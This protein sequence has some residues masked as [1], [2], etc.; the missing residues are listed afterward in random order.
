MVVASR[1]NAVLHQ[2]RPLMAQS[3]HTHS[4]KKIH[5]Y[6]SICCNHTLP[7]V[8]TYIQNDSSLSTST[9][10][11]LHSNNGNA[12]SGGVKDTQTQTPPGRNTLTIF[13]LM[14]GINQSKASEQAM[15]SMVPL[16][17]AAWKVAS[18]KER[19]QASMTSH[20]TPGWLLDSA[21]SSPCAMQV[22]EKST[23]VMLCHPW[24]YMLCRSAY[25]THMYVCVMRHENKENKTKQK[26]TYN[27]RVGILIAEEVGGECNACTRRGGGGG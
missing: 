22:S 24:S 10:H 26:V 23:L 16:S 15:A 18:S 6:I 7:L 8:P 14:R 27:I 21:L 1:T 19:S 20:W 11:S 4:G 2:F 9:S 12:M 5:T 25:T 13:R 17:T 3:K